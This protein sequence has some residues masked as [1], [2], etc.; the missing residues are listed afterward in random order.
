MKRIT[1]LNLAATFLLAGFFCFLDSLGVKAMSQTNAEAEVVIGQQNMTGGDP[2][3]GGI[4]ASSSTLY[5]PRHVFSDGTRLFVADY[6]NN[7]VL[8]YNLIPTSSNASADVVIGQPDMVSNGEN[9]GGGAGKNT[10]YNPNGVFF[11]GSKLFIAD[12]YN[13]RVLIY[14]SIPTSNNADADVVVGQADFTSNSDNQGGSVDA[15]TLYRPAGVF[16]DGK[17]LFVSDWRNHR[18]LIYNSI[19]TANNARADVVIGQPD[20]TSNGENQGGSPGRNTL[21][22]PTG[23]FFNGKKLF[24]GDMYNNRVFIY[25]SVPTANNANADIV[26]GQPDFTSNSA[27]QGGLVNAHSMNQPTNL[28]SYGP[29]LMIADSGNNRVLVYNS[30]PSSNNSSADVVVGQ[31]SM[32]TAVQ[33]Q[34]GNPAANALYTPR[35]VYIVDTKLF[36]C[37]YGNS[38]VLEYAFGPQYSIRKNK[39]K[40]LSGGEK[41]K[42]KKNKVEFRGKKTSYKKGKVKLYRDG[43]YKKSVK[44]KNNGKW[45]V[46]LK[47]KGSETKV[48]LLKYY[49]SGST[50]Q[51]NSETYVI[52]ISR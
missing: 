20:M 3:Q 40:T 19:P 24:V 8:I 31:P 32:T 49:N 11:D 41:M 12:I 44:I 48:F 52:E 23:I 22:R 5:N 26:L 47:D 43:D 10:L 9:Q 29:Y 39:S 38:R 51:M 37:D 30:I 14:N 7:R 46:S 42:V 50:L 34:G 1:A 13:N 45:K 36:V 25:N 4:A 17:R 18:V 6:L 16:S 33:N 28:F 21:Y 2:N 35:G 15:N 27:N